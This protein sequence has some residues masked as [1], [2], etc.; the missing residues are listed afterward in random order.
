MS[1]WFKRQNDMAEDGHVQAIAVRLKVKLPLAARVTLA[2]GGCARLWAH[3][4]KQTV[5]GFVAGMTR[6]VV[7]MITGI[8]GFAAILEDEAVGWLIVTDDGVQIPDFEKHNGETAKQ[9]AMSAQRAARHR[10]GG[11]K[12]NATTVTIPERKRTPRVRKSYQES[13]SE[14]EQEP[15]EET[16]VAP[17]C[18]G[19]SGGGLT[20]VAFSES[21]TPTQRDSN[22]HP[23]SERLR[24]AELLAE[25]RRL[26][27][28]DR[29]A[30]FFQRVAMHCRVPTIER[31]LAATRAEMARQTI[32]NP[33]SWFT[34]VMIDESLLDGIDPRTAGHPQR[35]RPK[36][37]KDKAA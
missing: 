17:C 14:S 5:D 9:R 34:R 6:E 25:M 15:E 2:A 10:S 27:R 21:E 12:S 8:E 19:L 1:D 22:P 18:S 16:G 36:A 3:F 23:D 33:G 28:D 29:S 13:E 24:R 20:R 4:D 35:A 31:V 37:A 30:L 32:T 7:D 11:G 26:E